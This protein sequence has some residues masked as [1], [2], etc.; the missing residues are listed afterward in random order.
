M[1]ADYS[2]SVESPAL[3]LCHLLAMSMVSMTI[4]SANLRSS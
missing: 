4:L 2:S 3:F 1:V